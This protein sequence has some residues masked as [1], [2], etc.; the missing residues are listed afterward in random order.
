MLYK[1]KLGKDTSFFLQR[2][3]CIQR[4]TGASIPTGLQFIGLTDQYS[5]AADFGQL[6]ARGR[7]TIAVEQDLHAV[8]QQ[9]P[10]FPFVHVG[11]P[12][13][14][15]QGDAHVGSES[16]GHDIIFH[17]GS[18]SVHHAQKELAVGTVLAADHHVVPER[19]HLVAAVVHDHSQVVPHTAGR[20][21]GVVALAFLQEARL[22][23]EGL[24]FEHFLNGLK[25]GVLAAGANQGLVNLLDFHN[26]SVLSTILEQVS[27]N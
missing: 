13:F 25:V 7:T 4:N 22:H 15:Q 8:L 23:F 1:R 19:I 26:H 11:P 18:Q 21:G 3:G 14:S 5:L 6:D 2:Q 24:G 9:G 10:G 17:G 27:I 16:S 20:H 12:L